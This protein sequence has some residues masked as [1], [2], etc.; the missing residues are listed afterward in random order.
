[1]LTVTD[2]KEGEHPA[3]EIGEISSDDFVSELSV[4]VNSVW[5]FKQ[6]V[7]SGD[8]DETTFLS[9]QELLEL[10]RKNK[11]KPKKKSVVTKTYSRSPYVSEYA[12]RRAKGCC[13]LCGT[14]APFDTNMGR[15]YLET[16]HII[17]LS[18]GGL[19]DI[20]NT[21]ALCPNCHRKM[22]IINLNEDIEKLM[23]VAKQS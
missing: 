6:Y 1:M 5:K 8:I 18:A 16:H 15:P 23:N 21:V 7:T 17:W 20:E 13:Q 14:P 12:K 2:T 19:D 4:F 22:H 11:E 10:A 9:D 3:I